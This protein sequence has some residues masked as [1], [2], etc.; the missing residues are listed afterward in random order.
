MTAMTAALRQKL[1]SVPL[2]V[3]ILGIVVVPLLLVSS[4][5][6]FLIRREVIIT[7]LEQ[8][9]TA[10]LDHL[11]PVLTQEAA[12][13]VLFAVALGALLAFSMSQVLIQPLQEL[14]EVIHRLESGDLQSRVR[15]WAGDE[16]GQVQAAFNKMAGR[17]EAAQAGLLE[18]NRQLAY[19]NQLTESIALSQD[20]DEPL[21]EALNE[22]RDLL[23]LDLV[24][25]YLLEEGGKTLKL[26]AWQ[27][28]FPA[29]LAQLA[30]R[31]EAGRS[32]MGRALQNQAPVIVTGLDQALELPP[33]VVQ[34]LEQAG[35]RS[36]VIT[37]I[38]L[39]GTALGLLN[40]LR[41]SSVS[42]ERSDI[43]LLESAGN[44]I[45]M[46]LSNASLLKD[47]QRKEA[48]LRRALQRSVE[49]QEEERKRLSREL[50]DE[51]GQALTSILIRLRTLQDE[52]D[53][54]TISHRLDGIRYLTSQTIDELGRMAMNLRPA[55]LDNLGVLP[56][57]RGYLQQVGAETG[58]SIVLHAPE[59][60]DRLPDGVELILYRVTQEGVTN[61]IRHSQA[62]NIEVQLIRGPHAIWLSIADDGKGFDPSMV[63]RGLGLIGI[64]ERV[65]LAQ[66]AFRVEST[67]GSGT[68]LWVELPLE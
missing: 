16:I 19:V 24:C 61:A 63:Y 34:Q 41:R 18:R 57:L 64:R 39:K 65:E 51:V 42:F 62:Q 10:V 50:H 38:L 21:N 11:Y 43:T 46:G 7:L 15:V 66:G 26:R 53:P 2:W 67:P 6:L 29:E 20:V 37:P 17:L 59:K 23:R 60:L 22:I 30:D 48:E 25:L 27:G 8:G 4:A 45:G 52:Q 56:A 35:V 47:L 31:V 49:L 32:T 55:A 9:Q 28:E 14:L 44:V 68:R 1:L 3:K 36:W 40:G 33:D 13:F 58:R 12:L 54:E 5:V